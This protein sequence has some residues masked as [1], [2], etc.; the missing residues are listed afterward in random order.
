MEEKHIL[1]DENNIIHEIDKEYTP[2]LK[3][4]DGKSKE[5][6]MLDNKYSI[7]LK[8]TIADN[9]EDDISDTN[10]IKSSFQ[11][12]EDKPDH[13]FPAVRYLNEKE[14]SD[15]ED[16]EIDYLNLEKQ[17]PVFRGQH[18]FKTDLEEFDPE[19]EKYREEGS[20]EQSEVLKPSESFKAFE[21]EKIKLYSEHLKSDFKDSI[22]NGDYN[23][24]KQYDDKSK[25]ADSPD[26]NDQTNADDKESKFQLHDLTKHENTKQDN[27]NTVRYL[28]ENEILNLADDEKDDFD[29]E[30][31]ILFFRGQHLV[32][33]DLEGFNY[34][35]EKYHVE[36]FR[37]FKESV[38]SEEIEEF[39]ESY[40]SEQTDELKKTHGLETET[41][42]SMGESFANVLV[43]KKEANFDMEN[44]I[45]YP[46]E[47]KEMEK[48]YFTKYP[49]TD[50]SKEVAHPFLIIGQKENGH[51]HEKEAINEDDN[52][53]T[54]V[55]NII[56]D[57][58]DENEKGSSESQKIQEN[59]IIPNIESE[60]ENP[61]TGHQNI[62][63]DLK[64]KDGSTEPQKIPDNE[65]I[66]LTSLFK[67]EKENQMKVIDNKLNI[68][69][70]SKNK[71]RNGGPHPY[72]F[73]CSHRLCNKN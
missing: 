44:A 68:R 32:E 70:K 29:Q 27:F 30:K 69:R 46:K 53:I 63:K 54:G 48:M 59:E 49:R 19:H 22:E 13:L 57:L 16:D 72:R 26:I 60:D 1:Y 40:E 43:P 67:R 18:L 6:N 3:Q 24:V 61:I 8:E 9:D 42:S 20:G 15:L 14:I 2:I 39:E 51:Q 73:I 7:E 33:T 34:K 64:D 41:S 47:V 71:D 5:T 12:Y 4:Y 52:P 25:E 45:L 50:V 56:K 38:E 55:Q 36:D 58:K 17:I 66:P 35:D 23:M 28:H 11:L 62:I 65:M 37:E 31:E 10:N 21:E